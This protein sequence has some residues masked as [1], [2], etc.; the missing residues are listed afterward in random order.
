MLS[1]ASCWN[2]SSLPSRVDPVSSK[3]SVLQTTAKP[4]LRA[5]ELRLLRQVRKLRGLRR[6]HK[7][8]SMQHDGVRG[9]RETGVVLHPDVRELVTEDV[10]RG[11]ER[12]E[13]RAARD[14][15]LVVTRSI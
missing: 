3:P 1:M 13:L 12:F 11:D 8:A 14:R 4:A 15:H 5:L 2:R 6:Q 7:D 9:I 10:G